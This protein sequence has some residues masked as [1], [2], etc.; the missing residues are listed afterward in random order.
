[1]PTPLPIDNFHIESFRGLRDV[2]LQR[3][4]RC[5]LLVGKNNCGKTSVLEALA[6]FAAP[7]E[8]S[9]WAATAGK[10]EGRYRS[11]AGRSVPIDSIRWLF[12]AVNADQGN[13]ANVEL[14]G[15]GSWFLRQ[16]R[17]SAAQIRG[18]PPQPPPPVQQPAV[19]ASPSLLAKALHV[20]FR[21]VQIRQVGRQVAM[22][23]GP[24]PDPA[25]GE[26]D[27]QE[28][29]RLT[30]FST[31]ASV[32]LAH[33]ELS[34]DDRNADP[35]APALELDLWPSRGFARLVSSN[36]RSLPAQYL[37]PYS[38]RD[39]PMQARR[40][41]DLARNAP[42]Y[43]MEIENILKQLDPNV[44]RLQLLT[45]GSNNEPVLFVDYAGHGS[46]PV[47]IVGDGLRRALSIALAVRRARGGLLLIDEIETALHTS[48]L[49]QFFPWLLQICEDNDVQLFA[50]THS[51]EAIAALA[52][53][54]PDDKVDALA[55]YR[56]EVTAEKTIVHRH[57]GKAL[58]RL[59]LESGLDV[60]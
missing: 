15:D 23:I 38:H 46:V 8:P 43:Q 44:S 19:P 17:V 30:V 12:P 6:M 39:E 28:G 13:A 11:A 36:D 47:R 4:A 59:V 14:S 31:P 16:V 7:L 22:T 21:D 1:M 24:A 9:T 27:E 56:L 52:R 34:F 2:T 49:D 18:I 10:R 35:A 45:E 50:T 53:A 3:L 20:L 32:K 51:L 26:R 57:G 42:A 37:P 29:L 54:L 55:T 41:S 33:G 5:N 40:Y 58:E 60:R 48:A 25:R